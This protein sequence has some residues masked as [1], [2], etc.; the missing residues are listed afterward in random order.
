MKYTPH[1]DEEIKQ[2]LEK[3]GVDSIDEL[4]QSIPDNLRYK[5]KLNLDEGKSEFEIME[6]MQA[7]AKA[8]MPLN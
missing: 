2:M 4:F 1:T 5:N 7:V 3:I 8:I 6:H